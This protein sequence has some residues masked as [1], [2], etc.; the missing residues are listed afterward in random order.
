[1]LGE[2]F[3]PASIGFMLKIL[4]MTWPDIILA[5]I[6]NEIARFFLL[7]LEKCE[8]PNFGTIFHLILTKI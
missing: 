3:M 1:M 5:F 8:H 7:K 2:P 6:G 4:A